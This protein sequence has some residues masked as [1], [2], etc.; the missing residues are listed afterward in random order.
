MMKIDSIRLSNEFKFWFHLSVES[1]LLLIRKGFVKNNNY[2]LIIAIFPLFEEIGNDSTSKKCI[3]FVS[4]PERWVSFGLESPE[5]VD[6]YISHISNTCKY[7]IADDL[8]V[9]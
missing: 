9:F 5:P 6:R 2:F 3:K 7:S 8:F 4:T 1:I